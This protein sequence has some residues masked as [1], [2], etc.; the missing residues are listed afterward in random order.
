MGTHSGDAG[1]G[2][3]HG[4]T[5]LRDFLR[6]ATIASSGAFAVPMIATVNTAAAP[7]LTRPHHE[8]R[9]SSNRP[10]SRAVEPVNEPAIGSG[11]Q[12]TR[13][14][15][16]RVSRRRVSGRTELPR[17]GADIDRN[18]TAGLATTA[19][20]AA[21]VLWSAKAQPRP[22]QGPSLAGQPTQRR[23]PEPRGAAWPRRMT[24][25]PHRH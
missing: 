23:P 9:G 18:V 14:G 6:R 2:D 7:G 15:G 21:L 24:P 13:T 5:G 12:S 11:A 25:P 22:A 16:S 8:W 3:A 17:T 4:A 20:G 1:P 19:G 10:Q